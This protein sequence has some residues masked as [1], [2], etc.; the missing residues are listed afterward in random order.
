MYV[1]CKYTLY[2]TVRIGFVQIRR[3]PLV[4]L[5]FRGHNYTVK[6]CG[7]GTAAEETRNVFHK[8]RLEF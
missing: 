6:R 5:N 8:T 4:V 3:T 2:K 7:A 1:S